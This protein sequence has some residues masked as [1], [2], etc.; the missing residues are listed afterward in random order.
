[1]ERLLPGVPLTSGQLAVVRSASTRV[2]T[3]L[4]ALRSRAR[5]EG[6]D[7]PGPS[8]GERA[9]LQAAVVA[10]LRSILDDD[11]RATLDRNLPLLDDE[12]ARG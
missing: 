4:F 3:E 5:H 8:A 10:D 6:R 12:T 9:A 1:M 11:Q 2:Q 7:W